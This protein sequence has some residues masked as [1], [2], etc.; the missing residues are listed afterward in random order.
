MSE[1]VFAHWPNR[2]T[3]LR[4][5]GSLVLFALLSAVGDQLDSD[6]RYASLAFW[7]GSAEGLFGQLYGAL[8]NFSTYPT[9]IFQGPVKW[10]LFTMLPAGFLAGLPVGL[11][12]AAG[13]VDVMLGAGAVVV[14][15]VA[16]HGT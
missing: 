6:R 10:L 16:R 9:P 15:G 8:T 7:L 11:Q 1:G 5:L 14:V 13:I 4:F 2:I 12:V 3:L